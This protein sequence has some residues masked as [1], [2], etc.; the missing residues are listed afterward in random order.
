MARVGP[1][2]HREWGEGVELQ[3]KRLA[4]DTYLFFNMRHFNTHS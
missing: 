4:E 2:R 3:L 1:K